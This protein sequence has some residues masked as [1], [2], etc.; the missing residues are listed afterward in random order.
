MDGDAA[1]IVGRASPVQAGVD[2]SADERVGVPRG[3][4]GYRLYIVMS[5]QKHGRCVG[6]DEFR[7]DDFPCA[8]RA[9]GIVGLHHLGVYADLAE[10]FGHKFGGSFHMIRG[11]AFC[12]NGL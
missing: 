12:R 9:I 2:Y 3:C 11:D 10:L 6:V 5:V 8:W 1:A 7:S 4:V